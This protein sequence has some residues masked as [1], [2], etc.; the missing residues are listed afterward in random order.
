M[1][2]CN[3]DPAKMLQ[4]GASDQGLQSLLSKIFYAKFSKCENINQKTLKLPMD[5]SQMK[6]ADKS[7]C[8]KKVNYLNTE[9]L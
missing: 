5:S 8:Q 4:N 3:A 2:I 7:T 9:K 6:R 1:D